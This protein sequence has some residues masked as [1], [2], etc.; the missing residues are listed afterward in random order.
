MI[1]ASTDSNRIG[2]R[3]L[4]YI[5]EGNFSGVVYPVNASSDVVQGLKAYP[6]IKDIPGQVDQAIIVVPASACLSVMQECAE[7]GVRTVQLYSS[8]FSEAGD[9][10][11]KQ[12]SAILALAQRYGIRILGPNSI[13][14]ISLPNQFLGTFSSSLNAIVPT[15]GTTALVT[16]SGAFGALTYSRATRHGIGFSRIVATGNEADI[17]VAE[18][19]EFLAHDV[20]TKTICVAVEGCRDGRRLRR[21]LQTAAS[22]GKPVVF[23]KVGAS[24]AGAQAAATHTGALAGND[25]I[26]DTV[27]KECGAYRPYTID[28]MLDMAYLAQV[29]PALPTN[30]NLGVVTVSG[31]IGVLLAD[32]ASRLGLTLPSLPD[33]TSDRLQGLLPFA[34]AG[35]PFDTTADISKIKNGLARSLESI[36]STTDWGAY[37][38]FMPPSA[39]DWDRF[40]PTLQALVEMRARNPLANIV[41]VGTSIERV[42]AELAK[43]NFAF[44]DDPSR[45]VAAIAGWMSHHALRERMREQAD[46]VDST[47]DASQATGL[48][49]VDSEFGAKRVLAEFGI[50]VLKEKVCES[51]L[52][53]S[54]FAAEVGYPVVAKISSPDIQHKTE[55]NGVRLNL[56]TEE[57]LEH[58]FSSIL[59]DA[60]SAKPDAR[61]QG[62]LIAPQVKDGIEVILGLQ[63]DPIFGPTV[64]VGM[65]GT[66]VELY[67]DVAFASIP[68]S[69]KR[70]YEL[71]KDVKGSALLFGWRGTQALNVEALADAVLALSRFGEV[72][73]DKVDAVDIN[74]LRVSTEGVI[75][76]DA[77]VTLKSD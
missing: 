36:V 19:I 53:A 16:Q 65:G 71:I 61:L 35:N 39:N 72:H 58:A 64:M 73:A 6:S 60:A 48:S 56:R 51:V 55:V 62:V 7:K 76:L 49:G 2:G 43:H 50:P 29:L 75:C 12:Q 30:S 33:D 67:R 46:P 66:A 26:L 41:L 77:V 27:L 59:A 1:G 14:L 11:A 40:L 31:G 15:L 34:T 44:M 32:E 13:G 57:E 20:L 45:A 21:A 68:I 22:S 74:P 10:G 37:I 3:V 4:R 24:E 42:R 23:M 18:V 8:G 38:V 52:E 70:A 17:D 28:Q 25:A 63:N 54:H 69:R 47:R 9:E 5:L